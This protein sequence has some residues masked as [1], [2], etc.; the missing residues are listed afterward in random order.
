MKTKVTSIKPK[1]ESHN[2]AALFTDYIKDRS[3]C[4]SEAAIQRC[5]E[6]KVF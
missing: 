6:E 2:Q 5:S 4:F 1:H 3:C